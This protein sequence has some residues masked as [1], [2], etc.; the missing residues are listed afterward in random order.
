MQV[1]L[2]RRPTYRATRPQ[3]PSHHKISGMCN[4]L[5]MFVMMTMTTTTTMMTGDAG[6]LTKA[7]YVQSNAPSVPKSSQDIRYVS[8]YLYLYHPSRSGFH[9]SVFARGVTLKPRRLSD[10]DVSASVDVRRR[11]QM[12]DIKDDVGRGG[13]CAG[14]LMVGGQLD[15]AFALALNAPWSMRGETRTPRRSS[16]LDGLV[17]SLFV[18]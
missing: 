17:A 11:I 3:S 16:D 18:S 10:L 15:W 12:T 2:P 5:S 6:E 7:T 1:N 14:L 4:E 13:N 9:T 8:H